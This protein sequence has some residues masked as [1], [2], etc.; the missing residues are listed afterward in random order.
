MFMVGRGMGRARVRVANT[1]NTK[2]KGKIL[3]VFPDENSIDKII[4]ST[5]LL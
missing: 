1:N 2:I 4:H 5:V 3:F